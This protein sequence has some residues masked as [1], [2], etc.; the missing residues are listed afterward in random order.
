MARHRGAMRIIKAD[1]SLTEDD[2]LALLA[3]V[4]SPTSDF[5]AAFDAALDNDELRVLD[6][7][8]LGLEVAA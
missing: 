4:V 1:R 3:M 2:R 5:E 7:D 6:E 8:D